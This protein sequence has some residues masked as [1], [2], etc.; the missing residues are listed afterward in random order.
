MQLYLTTWWEGGMDGAKSNDTKKSLVLFIFFLYLFDQRDVIRLSLKQI[1][2]KLP[3]L[4]YNG[5]EIV[6]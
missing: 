3:E 5:F 1:F 6:S 4:S 2:H